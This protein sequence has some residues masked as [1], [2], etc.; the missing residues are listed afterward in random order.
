MRGFGR[1]SN[2]FF[3][4]ETE[5]CGDCRADMDAAAP[6]E[7]RIR[8]GRA[9][10]PTL[11]WSLIV[12]GIGFLGLSS[13]FSQAERKRINLEVVEQMAL[14]A[15]QKPFVPAAGDSLLPPNLRGLTYDR[16]QHIRFLPEKEFWRKD[17]LPFSIALFHLGYLF[18]QPVTI[19]EFTADY[20]QP[21]R[22]SR[23]F[24]DYKGADIEGA[25]PPDLGYAGF[26]IS[27]PLN[28]PEVYDEIAKFQ[29]ASY[30]QILAKGQNHGVL[31]RGLAIDAGI[32]GVSEEFPMFTQFW[33]GKPQPGAASVT[34]FAL[35]NSPSVAGAYQFVL[36][37]G[38]ATVADVQATLF[39]RKKVGH[40]GIAPLTSMFWFGEN[41]TKPFDDYR[42]EVH[43][44]DGLVMKSETG[45]CLW[46]P[47][48]NDPAANRTY[49]FSFANVRGF[50]L[51]QRDR[52]PRSYEDFEARYDLRPGVWIEPRGDWGPGAIRL[53]ELASG[54]AKADNIVA[55]WE[56]EVA[57][58]PGQPYRL[59][60]RQSWAFE[61]NPAGA[62]AW[63]VATRSGVHDGQ[64]NQRSV[65]LEFAGP[66]LERLPKEAV[67][68]AMVTVTG[69][70]AVLT[71]PPRV[72]RYPGTPNWRVT[73]SIKKAKP[74][75]AAGGVE[76]RCSLRSGN[77]YLSETWTSWLPL[78]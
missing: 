72:E 41:T 69:D 65:V 62:G 26:R 1:K 38:K 76:V 9:S 17:G 30:Y 2:D 21:I 78:K 53:V 66:T 57:P 63:V 75:S 35:L 12:L 23:E 15:S 40:L 44:S 22:F 3:A 39:F 11:R 14:E 8:F 33:L 71:S 49:T 58:S 7:V 68:E 48:Q 67:P 25:L 37:P 47:L 20:V 16:Y 52:N 34:V 29:G 10:F 42:P 27:C 28:A 50:G 18:N 56:P 31:A 60:F 70:E 61:G 43:N 19:H 6:C 73:F 13:A 46:R 64:R 5:P 36:Q 45:E 51:I 59:T 74:E 32:D 24:F 54:N 4:C 77:D 55:A